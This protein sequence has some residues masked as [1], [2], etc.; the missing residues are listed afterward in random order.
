MDELKVRRVEER[1]GGEILK[2]IKD[3]FLCM[4]SEEFSKEYFKAMFSKDH[5]ESILDKADKIHIYIALV[6]NKIVAFGAID[7]F[8]E[9][10]D[11][12][13]I[14]PICVLPKF[15]GRGIGKKI[16]GVLENDEYYIRSRRIELK[17]SDKV[18]DFYKK[19]GFDHKY[20][21]KELDKYGN[22]KLEKFR[23]R[24]QYDQNY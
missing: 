16:M 19:L 7:S 21:L 13:M 23:Y 12:S 18:C 17:A 22:Y 24:L 3:T 1:E 8:L 4:I 15:Q 2:L 10:E 20:N 9:K 11:E 14:Y 5:E 6:N